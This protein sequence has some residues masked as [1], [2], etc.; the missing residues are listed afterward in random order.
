ME[1]NFV[2]ECLSEEELIDDTNPEV[3][4]FC[5]D[6]FGTQLQHMKINL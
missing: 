1:P 4:N 5:D 3:I 6:D 2:R